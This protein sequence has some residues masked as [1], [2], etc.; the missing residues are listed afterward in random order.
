MIYLLHLYGVLKNLHLYKKI[1]PQRFNGWKFPPCLYRNDKWYK[2][3]NRIE[4]SFSFQSLI[5]SPKKTQRET[6][7]GSSVSKAALPRYVSQLLSWKNLF[8]CVYLYVCWC[9]CFVYMGTH[10][11]D[12]HV[13]MALRGQPRVSFSKAIHTLVL[14]EMFWRPK[15]HRGIQACYSASPR[16]L[17]ALISPA[18]A[19]VPLSCTHALRIQFRS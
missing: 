12:M 17:H 16:D 2:H 18:H 13:C 10:V 4:R 3:T 14:K 5:D 8:M 6:E 7:T 11:G 15:A 9:V 1:L 19:T